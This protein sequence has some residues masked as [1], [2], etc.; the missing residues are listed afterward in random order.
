[1]ADIPASFLREPDHNPKTESETGRTDKI[2][3]NRRILKI[4]IKGMSDEPQNIRDIAR[5]CRWGG[6]NAGARS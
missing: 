5:R 1:M 2:V 3:V 6:E 4:S